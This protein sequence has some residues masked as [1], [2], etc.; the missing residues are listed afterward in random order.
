MRLLRVHFFCE[1]GGVTFAPVHVRGGAPTKAWMQ[2]R[3]RLTIDGWMQHGGW[4]VHRSGG[5]V[6]T[7][8]AGG[9]QWRR[10]DGVGDATAE[11]ERARA[12]VA[13][14]T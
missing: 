4:H 11:L 7:D 2:A 13:G 10:V 14:D 12:Y 9:F 3:A 6:W 8:P 1:L 5:E